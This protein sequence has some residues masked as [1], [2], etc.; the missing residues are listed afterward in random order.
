MRI[1]SPYIGSQH[2]VSS[3]DSYWMA[4][5]FDEQCYRPRD[6]EMTI[7]PLPEASCLFVRSSRRT[8]RRA[9]RK[10]MRRRLNFNLKA[11]ARI[12]PRLSYTRHI[13]STATPQARGVVWRCRWV[14]GGRGPSERE[15]EREQTPLAL[16][17]T[18]PHTVGYIRGLAGR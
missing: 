6:L 13:R 3:R 12:W 5:E 1:S 14:C 10:H 16:R 15:R 2:A 17:G 18:C 7:R 11:R 8:K 4:T 9:K